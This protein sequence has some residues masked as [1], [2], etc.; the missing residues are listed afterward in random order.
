MINFYYV[1]FRNKLL[2]SGYGAYG[3][4]VDLGFSVCHLAAVDNGWIIAYPHIRGGNDKGNS[5]H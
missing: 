1:A 4:K 2:I 3:I 5:W